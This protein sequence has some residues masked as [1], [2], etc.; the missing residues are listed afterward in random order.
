MKNIFDLLALLATEQK[1]HITT[2]RNNFIEGEIINY[3]KTFWKKILG[4]GSFTIPTS[5]VPTAPPLYLYELQSSASMPPLNLIFFSI[6]PPLHHSH[7]SHTDLKRH[8]QSK[9]KKKS[10]MLWHQLFWVN[11]LLQTREQSDQEEFVA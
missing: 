6:S 1:N 3:V 4:R 11:N 8:F 5:V 9:M 2:V 10:K 7:R